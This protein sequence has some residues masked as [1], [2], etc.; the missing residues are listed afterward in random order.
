[1]KDKVEQLVQKMVRIDSTGGRTAEVAQIYADFLEEH[2][3]PA[4]VDEYDEGMAN[5]EARIGRSNTKS[6]V[7]SG[8]MDTVRRN[9]NAR[10]S[11]LFSFSITQNRILHINGTLCT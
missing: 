9:I 7:I 4:K 5:V 3:I 2:G 6:V 8:H 10:Y 11:I 1:M